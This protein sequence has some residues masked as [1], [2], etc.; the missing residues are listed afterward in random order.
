VADPDYD[1]IVIGAGA[2][3]LSAALTASTAGAS[4]LVV[5][6][7]SAVGGSSV[8]SGG[9]FMAA[10][11]SVQRSLGIEDSPA[12]LLHDYLLFNQYRVE[13]ALARQLAYGSGPAV[14]WLIALGVQFHP[15]LA[16]GA[17]ER[18][19]RSHV[20]RRG[21]LGIIEVLHRAVRDAPNIDIALGRRINRLEVEAGRV[22]GVAVDDDA[23]HSQATV[24]AT[25]GFGANPA[26]WPEHLPSIQA[27]GS[28]AWYIGA[29][30]ARGDALGLG[31][32]VGA[33]IVGHDR[34]LLLP[35][36][37]FFTNLEPYFPG[38][39]LMV[40]RAGNRRVDE[41]ASYAIMEVR[42]RAYGP[43]CAVFDDAAKEAFRPGMPG[44]YKQVFPGTEG[45]AL[46]SNWRSDNVDAMVA[47]GKIKRAPTLKA[48]AKLLAISP[49]GLAANIERYNGFVDAGED[50]EYCKDPKFLRKVGSPPFYGAE[51]RL[52]VLCLT[53]K[54]LRIDASAHVLSR[55]GVPIPGLY[56]AGEC[57]G[58][59]L[60]DVYMGSGNSY[61]NCVVFGRTAGSSAVSDP[62][63]FP[64][65][66]EALRPR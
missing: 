63:L 42:H 19:P 44:A 38:W 4:V 58:G 40:D 55:E 36:P 31:A 6:S 14:E 51:L 52:G 66:A 57:T 11:T 25:G 29:A 43:M 13:P 61:A 23:V 15:Q 16:R 28:S 24:V 49:G 41:S 20:P 9:V 59:V 46:P 45:R 56:A 17:E 47:S 26:M 62:A 1:V 10:G 60:G 12:D 27:A 33:E 5:E 22:I 30:G 53:S 37:D 3:G 39:L 64:A 7:E 65:I 21:G 34:A 2:A 18:L 35:T 8:L 32:E 48:L 54:G 50:L